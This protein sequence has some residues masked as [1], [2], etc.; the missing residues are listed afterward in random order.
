MGRV[1][2]LVEDPGVAELIRVALARWGYAV[3]D[4]DAELLI[5][6][7]LPELIRL[8]A[9]GRDVPVLLLAAADIRG[10]GRVSTLPKP[11]DVEELRW[12][13]ARIVDPPRATGGRSGRRSGP[14]VP[15]LKP[16]RTP[17]PGPS[18]G[19]GGGGKPRGGGR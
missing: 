3:G 9:E 2:L 18:G 4:G 6:D 5:V 10:L 1:G 13:V 11:F 7:D 15:G 12:E 19:R 14:P 8:R 16:R 17:R